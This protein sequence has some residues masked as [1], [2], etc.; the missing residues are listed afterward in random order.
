ME[1]R[2]LHCETVFHTAVFSW[3]IHFLWNKYRILHGKWQ[4]TVFSHELIKNSR[5]SERSERVSEFLINECENAVRCHLPW[6][7]LFIVC[8]LKTLD[9]TMT[10]RG[11]CSAGRHP[12]TR[13]A[14]KFWVRFYCITFRIGAFRNFFKKISNEKIMFA[15]ERIFFTANAL[16]SPLFLNRNRV[17]HTIKL[18]ID[19]ILSVYL[20]KR[21]N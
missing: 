20:I 18:I 19:L 6:R 7:I 14:G 2:F 11:H 17:K 1:K 21:F 16:F 9:I 10:S 3:K 8:L 15:G 13:T 4:R 5:T 12:S